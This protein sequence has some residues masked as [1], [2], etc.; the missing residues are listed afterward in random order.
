MK[1][2]FKNLSATISALAASA[3][4]QGAYDESAGMSVAPLADPYKGLTF[5]GL[6]N[7]GALPEY[8]AAHRSH[9]SHGSHGSH[10]SSAGS[11]R[12]SPPPKS[13]PAPIPAP[14]VRNSDPLGQQSKPLNVYKPSIPDAAIL[15]SNREFRATVIRQ[16][17]N[18]L[19]LSGYYKGSADGVMGPM[20]RDAVDVYKIAKGLPRGGYLDITTLN[21]LGIRIP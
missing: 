4:T 7:E 12:P 1:S 20:T 11:S 16:I 19:K 17:Q 3:A 6:L 10:R 15:Q 21:A 2:I 13:V 9:S 8:L 5:H 14:S 18:K